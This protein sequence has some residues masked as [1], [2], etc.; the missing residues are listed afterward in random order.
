MIRQLLEKFGPNPFD[1]LLK[2]AQKK[3]LKKILLT[4]NRGLGDV[5]LGIYAMK[6]R[7]YSYIPDAEISFLTRQDLVP[8]FELLNEGKI[9]FSPSWKRG[10][11]F[12]LSHTLEEIGLK[13]E[14]FDLIIENPNPTKWVK[15]QLGNLTPKLTWDV[16][17][18]LLAEK[19]SLKGKYLGVHV[20][21]ETTY[22]Y[23][24][25]WDEKR[26]RSFFEKW[27][28]ASDIP[29]IL[30][31]FRKDPEYKMENL[32]DLRGQTSLFEMLSII[33][34]YCSH[35]VVPDSGVLSIVYYLNTSFPIKIV[36]LWADPHQGVLKQNV[37]SPNKELIHVPLI[38][39][40]KDIHAI[41]EDE[42]LCN[43]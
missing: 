10:V 14:N 22:G 35:L 6:E 11:P 2:R 19:F 3:G 41:S 25:N 4:W 30:F 18:D 38:G 33:K 37:S 20:H 36:S 43:L 15:W 12:N 39:E 1:L 8:G 16:K 32:V 5:P 24:K 29:V 40:N 17:G 9:F 7:I 31:G 42:V 27:A 13:E 34:N 28:K 26:W 21:S 23:Q